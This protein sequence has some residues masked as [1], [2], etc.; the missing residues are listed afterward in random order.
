MNALFAPGAKRNR[1]IVAFGL[2]LLLATPAIVLWADKTQ[3]NDFGEDAYE[4]RHA[5]DE[6]RRLSSIALP[7]GT[8]P[9]AEF[10]P[11]GGVLKP[12]RA[13]GAAAAELLHSPIG[14]VAWSPDEDAVLQS[15]KPGLRW[16]QSR[17][18]AARTTPPGPDSTTSA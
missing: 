10:S 13:Q 6:A 11:F 12:R 15:L 2:S 1:L 8:L 17:W 3:R 18:S 16:G 4:Q 14:D 5:Q 9:P 7:E